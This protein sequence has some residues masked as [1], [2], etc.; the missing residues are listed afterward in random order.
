M[1][2][3]K[4]IKLLFYCIGLSFNGIQTDG[5]NFLKSY[6]GKIKFILLKIRKSETVE[7]ARQSKEQREDEEF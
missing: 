4:S 2:Y 3:L 1:P 5:I 6:S 7:R